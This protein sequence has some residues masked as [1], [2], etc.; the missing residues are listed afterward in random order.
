MFEGILAHEIPGL[1][2]WYL[3]Y[4]DTGMDTNLEIAK[5]CG[6]AAAVSLDCRGLLP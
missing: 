1:R 3:Q 4:M 2:V 5:V 6:H